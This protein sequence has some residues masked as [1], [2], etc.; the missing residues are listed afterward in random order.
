M[1]RPARVKPPDTPLARALARAMA[2][3]GLNA[4]VLSRMAGLD[5]SFVRDLFRGKKRSPSLDNLAKLARALDYDSVPALLTAHGDGTVPLIGAAGA[6]DVVAR[7]EFDH[8]HERMPAPRDLAHGA[9]VV[10]RG[11]S[12]LPVYRDGDV[13]FFERPADEHRGG[14][15]PEAIR[16]DCVIEAVDGTMYVKTVLPGSR[17][18]HYHLASYNRPDVLSDVRV[19]WAAPVLW[20]K[21]G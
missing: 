8:A 7:F 16:H 15:A 13:L 12:M 14:V 6:G 18:G 21:R 10:V 9:A 20:V 4:A 1:T 3:R 5:A 19:R 17:P 2:E 11:E